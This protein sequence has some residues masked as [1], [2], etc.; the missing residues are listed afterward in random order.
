MGLS[1]ENAELATTVLRRHDAFECIDCGVRGHFSGDTRCD[2]KPGS[3][4]RARDATSD[5][6]QQVGELACAVRQTQR[7]TLANPAAPNEPAVA[8]ASTSVANASTSSAPAASSTMPP[9]WPTIDK[10][11]GDSPPKLDREVLRSA[12]QR[13]LIPDTFRDDDDAGDYVVLHSFALSEI[14]GQYKR[15]KTAMSGATHIDSA[16]QL[17]TR[18]A[19]TWASK[20]FQ[21]HVSAASRIGSVEGDVITKRIAQGILAKPPS[22]CPYYFQDFYESGVLGMGAALCTTIVWF[23]SKVFFGVDA[24][25]DKDGSTRRT[26]AA[27]WHRGVGRQSSEDLLLT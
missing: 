21:I 12:L 13:H 24:L 16:A 17:R 27:R 9:S 3:N 14:Y 25:C 1:S 26:Y 7:P 4:K 18:K 5:L 6:A 11:E 15:Q 22:P 2:R 19:T 23:K 10:W 8:R 20:Q